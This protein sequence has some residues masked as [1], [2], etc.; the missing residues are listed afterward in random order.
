MAFFGKKGR[1]FRFEIGSFLP[2]E[3]ELPL[4]FQ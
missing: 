4:Y 1:F 3:P 2:N